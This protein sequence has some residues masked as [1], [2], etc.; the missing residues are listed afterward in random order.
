MASSSSVKRFL[1]LSGSCQLNDGPDA[2][3]KERAAAGRRA[4]EPLVACRR[5]GRNMVMCVNATGIIQWLGKSMERGEKTSRGE[6]WCR[7][8]GFVNHVRRHGER[9]L[10]AMSLPRAVFPTRRLSPGWPGRCPGRGSRRNALSLPTKA[11]VEHQAFTPDPRREVRLFAGGACT[12]PTTPALAA[13]PRISRHITPTTP[14]I[15]AP[16]SSLALAD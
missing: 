12:G 11:T 13:S 14:R 15:R 3:A 1:E 10:A 6:Q 5:T 4:A 16:W 8:S 9:A 2:E 7:V